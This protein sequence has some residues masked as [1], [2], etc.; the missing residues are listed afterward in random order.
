MDPEQRS[1]DGHGRGPEKKRA[2][3]STTEKL[4][5]AIAGAECLIV[6]A[7]AFAVF[8]LVE[9]NLP[10]ARGKEKTVPVYLAVFIMA[11]I[12]SVLYIWDALR[13]RNVV[14][15]LLHL[16][17]QLCILAYSILQIPQ[18][19][20]ALNEIGN[21]QCGNYPRCE[22]PDSLYNVVQSLLIVTPIVLGLATIAFAFLCRKLY[23]QFGW[24]EFHLVGASPEMKR[25]H[26]E[27][28]TLMSL[29]KLL[30]YF[31]MAFCLAYLILVA[32]WT[33]DKTELYVSVPTWR[34]ARSW[35]QQGLQATLCS[36]SLDTRADARSVLACVALPLVVLGVA[37]TG[38][39]VRREIKWLMVTMLVLMVVGLAYFIYKLASMF[40]PATSWLYINTRVTMAIF[41]A[42]AIIILIVTFVFGCICLT[43][44]GQGL[45]QA[46]QNPEKT[47]TLW[48]PNTKVPFTSDKAREANSQAY[49]QVTPEQDR[50]VIE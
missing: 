44:F 2:L 15:L 21:Q 50:M 5:M 24:A 40:L 20:N 45:A 41:S 22:G 47:T 23:R 10:V 46:H 38:V 8:G 36:H 13:Q 29:L 31:G 26:R 28:Q 14:Q 49:A 32:S 6:F 19:Y 16:W 12:F 43:N 35:I 27:Y 4:Y 37:L 3:A 34:S 7:I 1:A 39:A 17:F 9:A 18:T 11:Q 30:L 42:F 25:M 48:Q 33:I